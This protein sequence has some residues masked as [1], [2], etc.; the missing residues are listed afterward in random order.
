MIGKYTGENSKQACNQL[1]FY[2]TPLGCRVTE[3]NGICPLTNMAA[4]Q[5][6]PPTRADRIR[7]MSDED[8]ARLLNKMYYNKIDFCRRLEECDRLLES[9]DGIPEEKCA[10]CLLRWL[11]QPEDEVLD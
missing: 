5:P 6:H 2:N 11:R 4:S 10:D 1:C 3:M 7:S 9:D 8:L